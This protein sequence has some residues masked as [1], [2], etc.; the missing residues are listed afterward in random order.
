MLQVIKHKKFPIVLSWAF[1][2]WATSAFSTV[3]LTFV[4]ASY[5]TEGIAKDTVTGT[6]QWGNAIALSGIFIAILSPITGAISDS[7]GR[8][9]PWLFSFTAISIISTALLWFAKPSPDYID[10]ALTFVVLGTIGLEV[11]VA[12]YNA[13]MR[14]LV[15]DRFL[16]RLS[17]LAWGAGYAG[18]LCCLIISLL[19]VQGKIP[20]LSLDKETAEQIRISGPLVA[21]WYGVFALPLFLWV[22]DQKSSGQSL[23]TSICLGMGN[24]FRTLKNLRQEKNVWL[25]LLAHMIYTDALNT[26]FTFGGI[27]AAGTFGFGTAEIIQF[28]ISTNIAAGLGAVIFS[29][30]DDY[31]GSKET[32]II[33]LLAIIIFVVAL[34]LV[35]Q[36]LWFWVFALSLCLFV[37]PVQAASRALMARLCP[38]DRVVEL[39]GLYAFSGKITSFLGPWLVGL[40]TLL[41]NSQRVG[42]STLLIF[43]ALGAFLLYFVRKPEQVKI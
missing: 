39:F 5:F 16:G 20:W 36:Q 42:M 31:I 7:S 19:I 21:L 38:P 9:K 14:G 18:G 27:Y 15:S 24:F 43:F 29:F 11:A 3:I 33:S 28:G 10:W 6:H 23:L 2:D 41:F 4:F 37:G 40:F 26:L 1:Y 34:L 30:V 12:F 13:M 22:P 32:I 8:R 17:G 35:E 25:Y